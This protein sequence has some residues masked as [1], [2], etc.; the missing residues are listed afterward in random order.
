MAHVTR[1]WCHKERVARISCSS[2]STGSLAPTSLAE[3]AR[4]VD[5]VADGGAFVSMTTPGPEDAGRGVR[6]V[7]AF[8]RSDAARLAELVARVDAGELVI[9]VAERLPL[10][11]LAAVHARAADRFARIAELAADAEGG[12]LAERQLADPAAVHDP[13]ATGQLAGKTV[14]IP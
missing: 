8:V 11:E 13:A 2:C 6:T 4:L 9:E 1:V 3:N 7:R 5:L 10:A 14:L 12:Q